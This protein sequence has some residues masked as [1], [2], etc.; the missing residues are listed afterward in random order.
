MPL[1]LTVHHAVSDGY[2]ASALLNEL[3]TAFQQPATN[4]A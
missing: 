1:S 2:Q 4:L 3:Q